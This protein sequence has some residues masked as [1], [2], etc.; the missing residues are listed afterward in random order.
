MRSL[1]VQQ[2]NH[3]APIPGMMAPYKPQYNAIIQVSPLTKYN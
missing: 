2:E 1:L 3:R